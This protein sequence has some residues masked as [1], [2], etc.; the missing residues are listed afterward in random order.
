MPVQTTKRCHWVAQSY[1][2]AFAA[3]P[4]SRKKIWRLSNI[5]GAPELKPIEKV[6]V[7]FHLYAPKL[8]G[9]RDDRLEKKLADIED[10]FGDPIWHALCTDFLDLSWEPLRKM[11]AL[12]TAVTYLR[13]PLRLDE[14]KTIHHQIVNSIKAAPYL[15]DE[16]KIGGVIRRLDVASWPACRDA[17]DEDIKQSWCDHVGSSTWLAEILLKMRWSI[18]V[19]EEPVFVTSD[20]PVMINH[21]SLKFK[22]VRDPETSI[23][24]PLSPTR[25]LTMDH[26]HGEPA[27]KYYPLRSCPGSFNALIWRN[28]I[29]HMFTHR[30][31]DMVLAEIDADA[32]QMGFP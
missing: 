7:R 3:D 32:R 16:V 22:G 9:R 10:W 29:E 5:A 28:A 19:S 30:N 4:V 13:N 12:T 17:D 21:P 11:V 25:L 26:L 1:L 18:L 24:F 27:S 14:M 20:N 31:P 23:S 2:K 15:P 8:N 6:A